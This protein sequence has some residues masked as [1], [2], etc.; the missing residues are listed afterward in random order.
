MND[1][2]DD[3]VQSDI[4]EDT[5]QASFTFFSNPHIPTI[6]AK[7]ITNPSRNQRESLR[8]PTRTADSTTCGHDGKE[9]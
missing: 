2:G 9:A 8:N 3:S 7:I 4:I 5:D 6:A 1:C